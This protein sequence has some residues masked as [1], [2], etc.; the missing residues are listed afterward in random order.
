M[1]LSSLFSLSLAS[2]CLKYFVNSAIAES[3]QNDYVAL[4]EGILSAEGASIEHVQRTA[5]RRYRV[6]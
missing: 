2:M 6:F 4:S 5:E 3:T 1:Q